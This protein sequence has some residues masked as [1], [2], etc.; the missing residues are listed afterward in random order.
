MFSPIGKKF[1]FRRSDYDK[2]FRHFI[3]PVNI[4]VLHTFQVAVTI[5]FLHGIRFSI[6]QIISPYLRFD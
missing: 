2:K 6:N 1:D 5:F 4:S 3:M